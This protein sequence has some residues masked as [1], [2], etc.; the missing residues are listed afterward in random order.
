MTFLF[1]SSVSL[2]LSTPSFSFFIAAL[3]T[4]Y[5][6]HVLL[7][8]ICGKECLKYQFLNYK[9]ESIFDF[10]HFCLSISMSNSLSVLPSSVSCGSCPHTFPAG[11]CAP[12]RRAFPPRPAASWSSTPSVPVESRR[13]TAENT[14]PCPGRP[15][16][17]GRRPG[18]T[19]GRRRSS[20]LGAPR[21]PTGPGEESLGGTRLKER[22]GNFKKTLCNLRT[23]HLYLVYESILVY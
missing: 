7:F 3:C 22:G 18:D 23:L 1:S 15:C 5:S 8:Q 17:R 13:T 16:T 4:V 21:G 19:G 14:R 12:S 6:V 10:S 2:S 11:R 9:K 20:A